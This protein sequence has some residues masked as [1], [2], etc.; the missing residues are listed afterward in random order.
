ML[1]PATRC[2]LGIFPPRGS[3]GFLYREDWVCGSFDL[4]PP[5]PCGAIKEINNAWSGGSPHQDVRLSRARS[6][7]GSAGI[8]YRPILCF[9]FSLKTQW[10]YL[11]NNKV[12]DSRRE[13]TDSYFD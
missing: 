12:H 2:S 9:L 5:L 1:D 13:G 7:A 10:S 8:H 4:P 3:Q 6:V 11:G